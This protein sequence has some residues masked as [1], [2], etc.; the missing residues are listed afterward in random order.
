MASIILWIQFKDKGKIREE[1]NSQPNALPTGSF[2]FFFP[3][4]LFIL[5]RGLMISSLG[6][7]LPT[8][9]TTE[10][11][12]LWSAGTALAVYQ[13]SGF[14]G[15]L[16]GGTASDKFGRRTVLAFTMA[17]SSLFLILFLSAQ[18]WI[19]LIAIGFMN[20]TTQPIM[21]ALIQDSFPNNRSIANGIYMGLAFIAL[22]ITS[23]FVGALGDWIGL[24]SA[25]FWS[26]LFSLL[27]LPALLFIRSPQGE[28][29]NSNAG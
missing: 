29:H 8:L 23:V 15:A 11:A 5:F 3:V 26:G 22:S 24:K 12:N 14:F 25:F 9:M 17:G 16:V 2:K 1:S 21:L 18:N 10:G 4:T 7:Y 13:I 20:L 19:I 28:V 27:A 6:T